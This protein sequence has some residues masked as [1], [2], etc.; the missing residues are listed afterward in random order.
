MVDAMTP[1]ERVIRAV[2]FGTPDRIPLKH[3]ITGAAVIKHG[4]ALLDILDRYP[5]DYGTDTSFAKLMEQRQ[6]AGSRL[7]KDEERTDEWGCVW[8]VR[9]DGMMGQVV[10]HPLADWRALA[11]YKLPPAPEPT[12]DV[13]EKKRQQLSERMK[14]YYTYGGGAWI[15]ERMQLLRGDVDIMIDLMDRRPEVGEL[16][17]LLFD[18]AKRAM[19][20]GLL[21][22]CDGVDIGDDWGNQE[23][24]RINPRLWREFFK[25]RY[26]K[27]FAFLHGHNA[28]IRFHSCGHILEILPDL[29]E[30]GADIINIQSSCMP[31]DDLAR[32]CRG[33]VCLEVDIDRQYEMPYGAPADVRR[34]AKT[35]FD[36]LASPEGGFIWL[37][38]IGPDVPLKNVE[39]YYQVCRELSG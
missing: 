13:V 15:W 30:V 9:Q 17:D 29:I 36:T 35:C 19:T 11:A 23:Q 2:T 27:L 10:R 28:H 8:R 31:M 37:T 16:A 21:A 25:P 33:K 1:R 18:H 38:E 4:R 34:R 24:L 6:A 7:D 20:P 39:A 22:G 32:A 3:N 26:R 5:D 12:P 14:T